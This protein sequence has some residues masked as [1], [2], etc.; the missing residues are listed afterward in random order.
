M[1]YEPCNYKTLAGILNSS[2]YKIAKQVG[3]CHGKQ[4]SQVIKS[5]E[6]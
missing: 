5:L 1:I 6:L 4:V 2:Y 3:L